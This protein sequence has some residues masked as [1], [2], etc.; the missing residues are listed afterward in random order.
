MKKLIAILLGVLGF[1]LAAR[2]SSA[3]HIVVR[4]DNAAAINFQAVYN[5]GFAS[6]IVLDGV[7]VPANST[8][9]SPNEWADVAIG[10]NVSMGVRSGGAFTAAVVS[11]S[12]ALGPDTVLRFTYSSAGA[13]SLTQQ[14]GMPYRFTDS[15]PP[16][17]GY[18]EYFMYGFGLVALWEVMGIGRRMLGAS[19]GVG[20]NVMDV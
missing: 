5:G 1:F 13:Y 10:A 9:V 2:P 8:W 6:A 7:T 14:S 18:M 16:L 20:R 12:G 19:G 15:R 11:G 17:T 4:N 3:W